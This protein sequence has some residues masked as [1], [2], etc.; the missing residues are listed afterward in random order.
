MKSKG[1]NFCMSMS[2]HIKQEVAQEFFCQKGLILLE[3]GKTRFF[4]FVECEKQQTSK[5]YHIV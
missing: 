4:C 2:D 5:I 1:A 3:N